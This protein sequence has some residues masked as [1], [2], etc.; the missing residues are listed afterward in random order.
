MAC[1][2]GNRKWLSDWMNE[3]NTVSKQ[4][5]LLPGET[6]SLVTTKKCGCYGSPK[7]VVC[8]RKK[9]GY[10]NH[11]KKQYYI[12]IKWSQAIQFSLNKT[13]QMTIYHTHSEKSH[14]SNWHQCNNANPTMGLHMKGK[15]RSDV[16][17]DLT[18]RL[19]VLDADHND[20]KYNN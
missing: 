9:L 8:H 7:N 5:R 13:D 14:K 19:T 4:N 18:D 10:N 6:S 12:Q 15:N 16:M 2:Y 17:T 11:K 3:T 1:I 20:H